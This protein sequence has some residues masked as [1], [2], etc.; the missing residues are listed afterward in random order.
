MV[1]YY[2]NQKRIMS[3]AL[4]MAEMDL[5]NIE[6]NLVEAKKV[7]YLCKLILGQCKNNKG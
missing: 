2:L 3:C 4:N 5:L 7:I 1:S 6:C